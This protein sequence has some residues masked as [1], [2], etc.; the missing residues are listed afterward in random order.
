MYV[1]NAHNAMQLFSDDVGFA[2]SGE[3]RGIHKL[4]NKDVMIAQ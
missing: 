3:D 4:S 2:K 1:H